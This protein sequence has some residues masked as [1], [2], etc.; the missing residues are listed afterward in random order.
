MSR[1]R[2]LACA[3]T[4]QQSSSTGA[5]NSSI[6]H[7]TDSTIQ[8]FHN[9]PK[10][11]P[12]CSHC[13]KSTT[14]PNVSRFRKLKCSAGLK[15]GGIKPGEQNLFR[16]WHI[17]HF[18]ALVWLILTFFVIG[19]AECI[20]PTMYLIPSR[21]IESDM[22]WVNIW[23]RLLF[24]VMNST[25]LGHLYR[26]S[27]RHSYHV[28]YMVLSLRCLDS[29][30]SVF[31]PMYLYRLSHD[32]WLAVAFISHLIRYWAGHPLRRILFTVQFTD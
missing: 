17:L 4:L 3:G 16:P 15:A 9:V 22:D 26:Y 18:C 19:L 11:A 6:E 21:L 14:A 27:R 30:A 28:S 20:D 13:R 32:S 1:F 7:L 24:E 10:G 5:C 12:T 23:W 25:Y 8:Y 2:K 31:S 29:F